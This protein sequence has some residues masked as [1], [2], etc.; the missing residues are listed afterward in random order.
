[1][2]VPGFGIVYLF[3]MVSMICTQSFAGKI[4]DLAK[5]FKVNDVKG[6]IQELNQTEDLSKLDSEDQKT[7]NELRQTHREVAQALMNK[8]L[9]RQSG[10]DL[11]GIRDMLLVIASYLPNLG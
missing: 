11:L 3:L 6:V 7:L 2:Q 10:S 1:M 4:S 8:Y 9:E 5:N